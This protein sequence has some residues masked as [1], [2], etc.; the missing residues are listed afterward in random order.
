[1]SRMPR[2]L[3]QHPGTVSIARLP[4][5]EEPSFQWAAGVFSSLV[6]TPDETTIVCPT[7][8]VPRGV[9]SE[10]PFT[11]IEVAGPLAFGAVGVFLEILEPLAGVGIPVLGYSTFD[12]DWVLVRTDQVP[13]AADAWRRAGLVL[14]PASLTGGSGS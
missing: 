12:T 1:V 2:H 3:L 9:R 5:G 7:P 4:A 6:R 13:A 14:T 10:G 11:V 8:V